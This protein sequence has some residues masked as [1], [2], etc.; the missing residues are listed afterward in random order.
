MSVFFILAVVFGAAALPMLVLSVTQRR[1]SP[2][3][4]AGM[5]NLLLALVF[6]ASALFA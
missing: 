6:A 5:V 2:W 1:R 4:A 3:L